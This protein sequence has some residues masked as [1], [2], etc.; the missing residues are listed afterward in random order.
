MLPIENPYCS[1]KLTPEQEAEDEA[2]RQAAEAKRKANE[3]VGKLPPPASL[4]N[5]A[6]GAPYGAEGE[7][8][9][10][11]VAVPRGNQVHRNATPPESLLLALCGTFAG[12]FAGTYLGIMDFGGTGQFQFAANSYDEC[13]VCQH[14]D[15]R[16]ETGFF[17][18]W[19]AY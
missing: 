15:G 11:W 13:C 3:G 5:W 7:D 8:G 12:T 10:V 9:T 4:K 1:C 16:G 14:F 2:K 6:G 19:K 17:S 18:G